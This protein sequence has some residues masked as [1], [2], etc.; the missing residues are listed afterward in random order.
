M[1]NENKNQRGDPAKRVGARVGED[2]KAMANVDETGGAVADHGVDASLAPDTGRRLNSTEKFRF[3]V[4]F[5]MVSLLWAAPFTMGS[6]VL[7]PQI[8]N[9]LRGVSAEAALG[10]MN[11]IGCVFA[12]VA[13]IVFG[14]LSDMSRF[15][16]GKRTPWIVLGGIIGA[17]GFLLVIQSHALPMIIFGWCIV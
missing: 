16:V 15:R 10:M 8:F 1:G 17:L 7:L 11:S 9:S 13:N 14:A 3:A 2:I 12:L 4:G 6:G 5:V